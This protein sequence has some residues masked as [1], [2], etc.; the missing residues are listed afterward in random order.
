VTG[1]AGRFAL[2][3]IS[4][5]SVKLLRGMSRHG[6]AAFGKG[7]SQFFCIHRSGDAVLDRLQ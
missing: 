1:K 5:S 3:K 7:A 4:L 2:R 6:L